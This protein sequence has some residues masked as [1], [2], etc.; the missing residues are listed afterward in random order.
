MRNLFPKWIADYESFQE[1]SLEL[2]AEIDEML[3]NRVITMSEDLVEIREFLADRYN[4]VQDEIDKW[5][6]ALV[7]GSKV[8]L[9]NDDERAGWDARIEAEILERSPFVSDECCE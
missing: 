5:K 9:M 8:W 4:I 3:E 1:I 2:S 6:T 7:S